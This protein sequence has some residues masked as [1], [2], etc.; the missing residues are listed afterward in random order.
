LTDWRSYDRIARRYDDVWGDRFAMAARHLW[1][2][3]SPGPGAA[4]LDIGTGTGTVLLA[5]GDRLHDL[6]LV[7]GCDIAPGM[8]AVARAK[9]PQLRAVAADAAGLPFPA[10]VFDVVT[11]SFVLSHLPDYRR[12]LGEIHR[13]LK[14]DGSV[15][16]TGWAASADA[17]SETWT[18]LLAAEI[19]QEQLQHATAQ[20][21]PWERYFEQPENLAA[22]LRDTGF[23]GVDVTA[24]QVSCPLTL[25]QYLADRE[26]SSGAR[27]ARHLLGPDDWGRFQSQA[28]ATLLNSFGPEISYARGVLLGI[29]RR[30]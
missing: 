24:A 1:E 16:V 23:A 10:G 21:T 2:R 6:A 11:A 14:P 15:A 18:R 13:V 22:A 8:L 25:D 5:L 29:G 12:G 9:M 26:I 19:G 20:V 4:V 27:F 30:V 28:R 3:V 17:L 7:A